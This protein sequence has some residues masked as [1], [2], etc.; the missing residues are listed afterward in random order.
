ML[1][2]KP[3]I[4]RKSSGLGRHTMERLSSV[5]LCEERCQVGHVG[6]RHDQRD[7]EQADPQDPAWSA[8]VHEARARR[9]STRDRE[10]GVGIRSSAFCWARWYTGVVEPGFAIHAGHQCWRSGLCGE[11]VVAAHV[12]H[13]CHNHAGIRTPQGIRGAV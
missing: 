6:V 12:N 7:E 10:E 13:L 3:V 2:A 8:A 11:L 4:R 9:M 5:G 1:L